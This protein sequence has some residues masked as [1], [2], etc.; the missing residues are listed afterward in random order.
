MSNMSYCR[1]ENTY[2]DVA[3]CIN[4]LRNREDID[5]N[6]EKV[7][8]IGILHTVLEFCQEEGI[9]NEEPDEDRIHEVIKECM[10]EDGNK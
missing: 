7:S 5:S 3:D 4:A 9:I 10:G 2:N 6:R 1:H 8:A